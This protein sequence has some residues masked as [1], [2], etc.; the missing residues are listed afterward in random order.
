MLRSHPTS[1]EAHMFIIAVC[2]DYVIAVAAIRAA[3]YMPLMPE[4]LR[5]YAPILRFIDTH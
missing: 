2:S 5:R 3:D 4:I 1:A